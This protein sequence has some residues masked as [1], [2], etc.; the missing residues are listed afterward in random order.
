VNSLH[1][2]H[3]YA[4]SYEACGEAKR[5]LSFTGQSGA[6]ATQKQQKTID[7]ALRQAR[8]AGMGS[9]HQQQQQKQGQQEV[10]LGLRGRH[11]HL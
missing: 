1:M 10:T 6:F 11:Q 3:S 9:H 4:Q 5:Q 7:W 8:V 2:H